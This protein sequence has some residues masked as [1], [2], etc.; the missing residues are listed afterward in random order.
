MYKT[1]GNYYDDQHRKSAML[2]NNEKKVM[3]RKI[4]NSFND[5]IQL[6]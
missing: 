5:R 4:N 6:E 2:K 3:V 1:V